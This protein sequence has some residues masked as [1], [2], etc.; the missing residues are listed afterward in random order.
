MY[1]QIFVVANLNDV[2]IVFA[3]VDYQDG[4]SKEANTAHFMTKACIE[5]GSQWHALD[6][7]QPER[8]PHVVVSFIAALLS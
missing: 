5:R 4:Y 6:A 8:K 1:Q 7:Q 2:D 3:D